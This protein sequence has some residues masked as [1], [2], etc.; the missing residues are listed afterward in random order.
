MLLL[1][2]H[3]LTLV[4]HSYAL[5]VSLHVQYKS[6]LLLTALHMHMVSCAVSYGEPTDNLLIVYR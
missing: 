5:L 4:A 6:L 3:A 1:E 2:L